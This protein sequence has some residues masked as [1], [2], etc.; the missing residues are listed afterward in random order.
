[1]AAD[2][3]AHLSGNA[4]AATAHCRRVR[5]SRPLVLLLVLLLLAPG[6]AA[7]ENSRPAAQGPDSVLFVG[8][9]F[10]FYN[11]AI[12]THLRGLLMA[13]DP[14]TRQSIF[15]KSMT[16]SGA[17]LADHAGGLEQMLD[18]RPWDVVV[19][20][21]HSLEAIEADRAAGFAAALAAFS[22]RL[23]AHGA[24]PVLFM[25]WA[26]ADRPGM[27]PRLDEAYTRLGADLDL[28]IVPVGLAFA[29]A[30][31]AIPDLA[32]HTADRVHPSLAGTYL[33]AAVFYA[34]LYERSPENLDYD[35]GLPA[36]TA[37]RLREI[38]W[39]SVMDY[40]GR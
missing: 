21:G 37:R 27:T 13:H 5:W 3:A 28:E 12:Y 22:E 20:Q 33:A 26:Y 32:L 1:M 23:R 17:V 4:H 29:S 2:P 11:N 7:S 40:R 30:I 35:A 24:R 9:S 16:I 34:A 19:L 15:L 31:E 10:T 14:A 18:L 6:I 8:N 39:S 25:T 36:G 38:A